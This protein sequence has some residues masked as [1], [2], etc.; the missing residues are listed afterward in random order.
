MKHRLHVGAA[1]GCAVKNSVRQT[2]R[3]LYLV[4]IQSVRIS[5]RIRRRCARFFAPVTGFLAKVYD[6][7]IGRRVRGVK[8]EWNSLQEGFADAFGRIRAAKGFGGKAKQFFCAA[9]RAI[10]AH[11]GILGGVINVAAPAA[12]IALLVVTAQ[13]ISKAQYG[14]E[15]SY[16]G[17]SL[18]YVQNENVIGEA[19]DMASARV[20]GAAESVDVNVV[21]TYTFT[22]ISEDQYF[23]TAS[24]VCDKIIAAS[25]SVIE[26]A[27][28][29]YVDDAFIGAVKS[30]TDLR[31]ILQ[32]ILKENKTDDDT[33]DVAFVQDVQ[34]VKGMY[35]TGSI[36]S[37]EAMQA[38][39]TAT[40][41]VSQTYV[42]KEGDA[43]LSIAAKL[44]IT[45]RQLQNL[46]PEID[47]ENSSIHVGDKLVISGEKGFL[48]IKTVKRETYTASIPYA[49][50]KEKTSKLYIGS[51]PKVAVKGQNGVKQLV[52]EVTYVDGVEVDRKNIS[53]V[54]LQNAVDE[55]VLVGTL[56]RPTYTMSY[57]T[58]NSGV[59]STGQ[60]MWPVPASHIISQS[61]GVWGVTGSIHQAIDI[62]AP[63]GST[64]YAADSGTVISAGWHPG[65][66]YNLTIQHSNGMKTFYAHCSRLY[67]GS[68]AVVSKGTAIAAVGRTGYWATGNHLHFSVIVN[69]VYVNP[70]RYVK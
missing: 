1:I 52:D 37:S 19:V 59:Q 46:N 66:G 22:E 7:C 8:R 33:M 4:G 28:G 61:Y 29:L 41:E 45:L 35:P 43:P 2:G 23:V 34:L 31:F 32:S 10:A 25:D 60:L 21:P 65:Y 44:G 69:G 51:P 67:V 24:N 6:W 11:H 70:L 18:G 38:K 42:V 47:L 13:N 5:H 12:A 48:T 64:I 55:K 40:E 14:L 30:E 68:G 54:I 56:Q 26:E 27:A 63:S 16:N 36:M 17:T 9:G 15:I 62:Q 39:L 20:S 53:T 58:P 3:F 50:I 57:A 49:T